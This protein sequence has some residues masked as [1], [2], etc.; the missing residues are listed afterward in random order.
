M[1]AHN[2]KE[3]EGLVYV[4]VF[5]LHTHP[6]GPTLPSKR[7]LDY[8][9][10]VRKK[11]ISDERGAVC[12]EA[13]LVHIIHGVDRLGNSE[14]FFYQLVEEYVAFRRWRIDYQQC[15]N[16][17]HSRGSMPFSR[18]PALEFVRLLEE[19][20]NFRAFFSTHNPSEKDKSFD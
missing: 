17:A 7:D 20:S 6:D 8:A 1:I 16:L 2:P 14:L 3:R 18:C 13:N 12:V 15:F 11:R 4:P 5:D 9:Y 10:D 19:R